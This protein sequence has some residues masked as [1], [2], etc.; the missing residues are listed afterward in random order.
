MNKSIGNLQSKIMRLVN[1]NTS[2][3]DEVRGAQ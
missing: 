2:M 1:E 3:E